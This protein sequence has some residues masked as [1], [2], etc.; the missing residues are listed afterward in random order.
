VETV[1]GYAAQET[2][3]FTEIAKARSALIGAKNLP[4]RLRPT[5]L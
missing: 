4:T 2:T 3:I 1:K 5:V